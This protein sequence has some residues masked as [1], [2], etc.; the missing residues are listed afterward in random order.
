VKEKIV[1][2]ANSVPWQKEYLQRFLD[3]FIAHGLKAYHSTHD[4]PDH[5]AINVVFANNSWKK[6]VAECLRNRTPLLTVGRCFFGSRHDMVAIG[7]DGFNVGAD[8]CL[9]NAED[10]PSDRWEKHG[11]ELPP[12]NFKSGYWLVCGEFRDMS[13]WYK[14][15]KAAT[16]HDRVVF[17][18]HPFVPADYHGFPQAPPAGQDEIESVLAGAACCITYDSIAGCDAV[19]AGVPS[20]TYGKNAMA[21]DVSFKDLTEYRL[22]KT[23]TKDRTQWCNQLAY[24]QWSH[25]EIASGEFWQHLNSRR[26][27]P[28]TSV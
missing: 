9:P 16:K 10:C 25:D 15:I 17:R 20:I 3:G 7:W 24:C 27:D 28:E 6:T 26:T 4:V 8:F 22:S 19:L 1:V 13:S 21:R 18:P 23:Q 11:F 14:E 5:D 2:H 12:W